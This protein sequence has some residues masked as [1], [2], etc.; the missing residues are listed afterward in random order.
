MLMH[1]QKAPLHSLLHGRK[2]AGK[3]QW[4][5]LNPQLSGT[6]HLSE[7]TSNLAP[8]TPC[9]DGEKGGEE[10]LVGVDG[11]GEERGGADVLA[12]PWRFADVLAWPW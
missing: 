3:N 1:S 12:W 7:Q 8:G 2:L 4:L 10:R 5:P 6:S 9:D 11:V